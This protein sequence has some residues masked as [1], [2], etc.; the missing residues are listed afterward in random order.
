MYASESMVATSHPQASLAGLDVLHRGGN[1]VDAAIAAAAMLAVVEPAMSGLGGD[2]F[3]LLGGGCLPAIIAYNGSGRTPRAATPEA[4]ERL[5]VSQLDRT[6][7][8]AVTMPGAVQ[9]W[10]R[11]LRD[12]GTLG[13]DDLLRPAI[14]AAARGYLVAPRVAADWVRHAVVLRRHADSA[15][16]LLPGGTAPAAGTRI[17]NT[18]LAGVLERI[19]D[20]G[21]R[22]FY[23]GE[24]ADV[25]VGFLRRRGG[26]HTLD[27]WAATAGEYVTPISTTYRGF[28]IHECPP[29]GGG[30]AALQLFN[31]FEGIDLAALDPLG[32]ARADLELQVGR[33][34]LE[35]RN[36]HVCDPR[37]GDVPLDWLL[38]A[39]H[40]AELRDRIGTSATDP[41]VGRAT[42]PRHDD[43]TYVCVVDR[44]GLSVSLICSVFGAFGS[45]LVAPGTGFVLQ[46][47]AV[48]FA[49]DRTHPNGID[50]G[51]RPLH[52]ILPAMV[53]RD[54]AV[55]MVLGVVGG[56]YQPV[57]QARVLTNIIDH[58]MDPQAAIDAPRVFPDGG[59][60]VIERS[61]GQE[62]LV[63][64]ARRGRR[65]VVAEEPIGGAQ[66]IV[67]D[68]ERGCLIGGSDR[69]KD[70]IAL[71]R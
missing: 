41:V 10:E 29:N 16:A 63:E 52:T 71:G 50:G 20:G 65:T 56:D 53:T 48:G 9:A 6:S 61:Y 32:A 51:K 33:L 5:G 39:T 30:I 34:A 14:R 17:V 49:M 40:A 69:R 57:G 54:G 23:E 27:D 2:C 22:V 59:S 45:G 19:A 64:L 43:T 37:F 24:I 47:R 46:N 26:L 66:A 55:V 67:I 11:L 7:A 4:F 25:I 44:D 15:A 13:F 58:H 31:V 42:W 12:H 18:A 70:G 68:R 3:A 60:A 38:S 8:H 28:Q 36:A 1:A 62:V 21:A 35:D